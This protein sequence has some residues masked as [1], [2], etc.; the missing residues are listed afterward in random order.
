VVVGEAS[1]EAGFD[2]GGVFFENLS[3]EKYNLVILL[4][5]EVAQGEIERTGD[6]NLYNVLHRCFS[7]GNKCGLTLDSIK[8]CL[9][10]LISLLEVDNCLLV[11][12]LSYHFDSHI[13]LFVGDLKLILPS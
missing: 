3:A 10:G 1:S 13:F 5:L 6:L 12:G 7:V 2:I 4:G 8:E 11:L 9:H